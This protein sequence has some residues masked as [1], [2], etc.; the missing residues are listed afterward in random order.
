MSQHTRPVRPTV[1]FVP[2]GVGGPDAVVSAARPR[3]H[4]RRGAAVA[5]MVALTVG[6][7]VAVDRGAATTP[8]P[9]V[10]AASTS[11]TPA[12]VASTDADALLATALVGR[13]S[14]EVVTQE[15]ATAAM[16]RTGTASH[17][18]A[19]LAE[20]PLPGTLAL[21]FDDLA[22]RVRRDGVLV[23]EGTWSVRDGRL[24]LVPSCD[25]CGIALAPDIRGGSLRLALL[26]DTSPDVERVP[27]AAYATVIYCAAPFRRS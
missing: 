22:Y 7:G 18:D 13:W 5:V 19:V 17:R 1:G 9:P 4:G 16:V 10:P 12:R 23:D 27:D 3:R 21:Q 26:D 20:V 25:D 14:T 24:R 11:T 2:G 8:P 15:A 6:V